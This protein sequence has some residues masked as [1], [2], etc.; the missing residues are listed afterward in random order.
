M[1]ERFLLAK[2]HLESLSQNHS[3]FELKE[4]LGQLPEELDGTYEEAISR[5]GNQSKKSVALATSV[6]SWVTCAL[7]PLQVAQLQYAL[8]IQLGNNQI[9]E[10]CL[11]DEDILLSVCAGLVVID[12]KSEIVRFVHETTHHYFNQH[13]SRLLPNANADIAAACLSCFLSDT[14]MSPHRNKACYQAHQ[15]EQSLSSPSLQDAPSSR[16]STSVAFFA[17]ANFHT[18]YH[19]QAVSEDADKVHDLTKEIFRRDDVLYLFSLAG[20]SSMYHRGTSRQVSNTDKLSFAAVLG[21]SNIVDWL[22]DAGTNPDCQDSLGQYPLYD[23]ASHQQDVVVE[24]LLKRGATPDALSFD[25]LRNTAGEPTFLPPINVLPFCHT[26]LESAIGH[27]HYSTAT[28]LLDRGAR[29]SSRLDSDF[30]ALGDSVHPLLLAVHSRNP[31]MVQFVL[32]EIFEG[33][34]LGIDELGF[35]EALRVAVESGV[36]ETIDMLLSHGADPN[37]RNE[38]GQSA[39]DV[40]LASQWQKSDSTCATICRSLIQNGASFKGIF[41]PG[42]PLPFPAWFPSRR[43][44]TIKVLIDSKRGLNDLSDWRDQLFLL[45]FQMFGDDNEHS[46]RTF[47]RFLGERFL[48]EQWFPEKPLQQDLFQLLLETAIGLGSYKVVEILLDH[49]CDPNILSSESVHHPLPLCRAAQKGDISLCTLLLSRGAQ[50]NKPCPMYGSALI[51]ACTG[52]R[53]A[54][55]PLSVIELLLNNGADLEV[56]MPGETPNSNALKFATLSSLTHKESIE[57]VRLLLERGAQINGPCGEYRTSLIAAA[58]SDDVYANSV[59]QFLLDAGADVNICGGVHGNALLA[60]TRSSQYIRKMT[61]LLDHG[62]VLDNPG[63]GDNILVLLSRGPRSNAVKL[64]LQQEA[65]IHELHS[66]LSGALVAASSSGTAETMLTLLGHGADPNGEGEYVG[67]WGTPTVAAISCGGAD[68][69]EKLRILILH[70]ADVNGPAGEHGSILQLILANDSDNFNEIQFLIEHGANVN[71]PSGM[72]GTAVEIA[73]RHMVGQVDPEKQKRWQEVIQLL[74]NNGALA[75]DTIQE[76][77]YHC[78]SR[79]EF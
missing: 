39:I 27:G 20:F 25:S 16:K 28:I 32:R 36:P 10:D 78:L 51:A 75:N 59:M 52:R 43:K 76:V 60:A 35:K 77:F 44:E 22:L 46:T 18:L 48:G 56:Q 45:S 30:F 65:H 34:T 8:A 73:I 47:E 61:M 21:L 11:V 3:K 4:A 40:V 38:Y 49:G 2:L 62:A 1:I 31:F 29:L 26:A 5:I 72:H 42:R 63:I 79:M 74:F 53:R 57:K 58:A 14:S 41:G 68:Y 23:A 55:S 7:A 67:Q 17:Y 9:D 24:M 69:F 12:D 37:E 70:G 64:L 33:D 13:K 15:S 66:Y 6:F 71:T 19:I 50:A 54:N